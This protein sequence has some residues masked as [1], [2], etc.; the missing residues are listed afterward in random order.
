MLA[1]VDVSHIPFVAVRHTATRSGVGIFRWMLCIKF[2]DIFAIEQYKT[3]YPGA[4]LHI[5]HYELM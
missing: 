3:F 4:R 1:F 2:K 5:F